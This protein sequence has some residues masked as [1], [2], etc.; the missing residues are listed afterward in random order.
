MSSNYKVAAQSCAHY[1]ISLCI[2]IHG[3]V[4]MSA[5]IQGETYVCS[6]CLLGNKITHHYRTLPDSYNIREV[7]TVK[8]RQSAPTRVSAPPQIF[9]SETFGIVQ[10]TPPPTPPFL[11]RTPICERERAAA[12]FAIEV[13]SRNGPKEV[14]VIIHRRV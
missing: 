7:I 9:A 2:H 4:F 6:S 3:C 10:A 11:L 1:I 8:Y 5:H 12:A 13:R 14:T